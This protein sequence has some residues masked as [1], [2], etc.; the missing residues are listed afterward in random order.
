MEYVG[1]LC[2]EEK[3]VEEH[4][5]IFLREFRFPLRVMYA[6]LL[7]TLIIHAKNRL[8][9]FLKVLPEILPYDN[10]ELSLQDMSLYQGLWTAI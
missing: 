8:I 2:F 3:P 5:R 4:L 7:E 6:Q 1:R 10:L 9:N